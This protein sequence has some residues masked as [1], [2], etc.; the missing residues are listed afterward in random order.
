MDQ[1]KESRFKANARSKGAQPRQSVF[2][3][4]VVMQGY[5]QKLSSGR[6]RRSPWPAVPAPDRAL[7]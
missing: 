1:R 2:G 4:Q 7:V 6:F 5:L 3:S